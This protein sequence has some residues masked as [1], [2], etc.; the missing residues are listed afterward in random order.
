MPSALI[1]YAAVGSSRHLVTGP[2]AATAALSAAA[3]GDL[4]SQGSDAFVQ[5]TITLGLVVGTIALVAGLLRLGFL[6]SLISEPVLKGFIIVRAHDHR[7]AAAETVRCREGRKELLRAALGTAEQPRRHERADAGRR[8]PLARSRREP[9][10]DRSG[11]AREAEPPPSVLVLDLAQNDDLD[12][13]TLD[14]LAELADELA[15]DGIELRLAAVRAPAL[16][17]LGRRGL[18]P[19]VKI[20]PTL[21]AAAR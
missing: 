10:G 18:V 6:A 12:V 19:R 4:T 13:E 3:V 5:M 11:S 2:M 1:L 21:D 16:E 20:E 9:Q 15:G 8:S 17:L 7:R 14:T